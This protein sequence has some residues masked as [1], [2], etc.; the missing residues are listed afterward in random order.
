MQEYQ[1]PKRWLV[2]LIAILLYTIAV[3]DRMSPAVMASDIMNDL[4]VNAAFMGLL[5]SSYFYPYAILQIPSG[6]FADKYSPRKLVTLAFA[7]TSIGT[8][9]FAVAPSAS[10]AFMGR[11]V[12]G[13]GC[14]LILMPIYKTLSNWFSQKVYMIIVTTILAGA[15]GMASALAGVPL[16]YFV[17]NFGWRMTTQGIAT[18][19]LVATFAVWFFF[20]D[21]PPNSNQTEKETEKEPSMPVMKSIKFILSKWNFWMI[22]I[23]FTFNAAIL[24]GFVGVWSGL[25]YTHVVGLSRVEMS[26]LLSI[27]ATTTM[28]TPILFASIASKVKSRKKTIIFATGM[29]FLTM[30]YLFFRNGSFGTTEIFAWGISL[31]VILTAPGGL[32]MVVSREI[33]P[34]NIAGTANG[35]V[36]SICMLITALY[37]PLIGLLVDNAGYTDKLTPEMFKPVTLLFIITSGMSF[38]ASFFMREKDSELI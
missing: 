33:Y 36:Y 28:I 18:I 13:I 24:F 2:L 6:I 16:A 8:F 1:N 30:L 4:Q 21:H 3:F 38:L 26:T 32:Y 17:E 12:I 31:S 10:M 35:L 11:L 23:V 9:L 14:A 29:L 34:K 27:A 37:Q 20:K 22:A 25:Y 7:L 5:A 19:S 15:V